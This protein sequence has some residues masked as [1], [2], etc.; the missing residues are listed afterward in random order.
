MKTY[1]LLHVLL[2]SFA[3]AI[4]KGE[5]NV[6][7]TIGDLDGIIRTAVNSHASQVI[8][9]PGIYRGQA[10]FLSLQNVSD[11]EIIADGVTMICETK[12]RALAINNCKNVKIKGL[13]IDYYPLTFTQGDIIAVTDT[14]V[15]V[16]IHTGYDVAPYSRIDIVDPVTRGRKRGSVFVWNSTAEV[17]DNNVVRVY[18]P[19]LKVA[20]RVGDM[21]SMSTGPEGQYGAPHVL[22]MDDCRGGMILED[23][24]VHCGPGFGIFERGGQGK[25]HLKNCRIV[26]G[27]LPPGATQ[28][29][30]LSTSWDAIQHTLTNTGPVVEGC[31]VRDAG[32]DSWSVTWDGN[33]VITG[34]YAGNRRLTLADNRDRPLQVGDTLRTALDS[35]YAVISDKSGDL[36]ILDRVCPWSVGAKLYSPNRRCEHFILRNNYFRSPGRILIKAGHGLIENNHI[37][38]G[39]CGVIVNS[40]CDLTAISDLTIRNNVITAAG[41]FNPAP[42]SNQAGAI[43]FADGSSSVISPAGSFDRIVV[44]NNIFRDVSGVNMVFTSTKN[45]TVKGNIFYRTGLTTPNNTGADYGIDQNSVVYIKNCN[46]VLL[47]SNAVI[48]RELSRLLVTSGVTGLATVRGGV[49]DAI[50]SSSVSPAALSDK[51][52]LLYKNQFIVFNSPY[53]IKKPLILCIYNTLGQLEEKRTITY[54]H[55]EKIPYRPLTSG[56]KI[57]HLQGESLKVV[58]KVL[59]E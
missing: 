46:T 2:C 31:E 5:Q 57:V 53:E 18:Q 16:R 34:L 8:V 25:T 52:I 33:Y 1:I 10:P 26:P 13:T 55:K 38:S 42:W 15:D 56:M 50:S 29:R 17:V 45:L 22:E 23:I 28:E 24:T 7:Y 35:E 44:E 39:H 59:V 40:E 37:D 51:I 48:N 54:E 20:A 4:A 49:F 9:P 32:D 43:S 36:L 6:E 21:A 19:D 12:V 27:P 41:H 30:L 58:G 3:V 14:Y 11:L 47:D